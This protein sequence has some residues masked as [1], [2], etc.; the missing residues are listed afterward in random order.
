MSYKII[1]NYRLP[2]NLTIHI[3]DILHAET[4]SSVSH[5]SFCFPAG[6]CSQG[7]Q[8][9]FLVALEYIIRKK[10]LLPEGKNILYNALP[11]QI[12]KTAGLSTVLASIYFQGRALTVITAGKFKECHLKYFY[13]SSVFRSLHCCLL[14]SCLFQC[15]GFVEPLF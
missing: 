14:P 4:H 3:M 11:G 5:I 12:Q 8:S 2:Q 7:M 9:K 6:V 15:H 10:N 13:M 1:L